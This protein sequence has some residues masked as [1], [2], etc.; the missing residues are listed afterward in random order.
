MFE[1]LESILDGI[2][3]GFGWWRS[4]RFLVCSADI[5]RL[6][7]EYILLA[8][9]ESTCLQ[10][11]EANSLTSLSSSR[12]SR[13]ASPFRRAIASESSRYDPTTPVLSI[14]MK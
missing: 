6:Q 12:Y 5:Q 3:R 9:L 1:E 11:I 10:S 13:F 8:D 4:G 14:K 7:N 2:E